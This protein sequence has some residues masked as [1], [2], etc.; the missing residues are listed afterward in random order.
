MIKA[1]TRKKNLD[2]ESYE[3]RSDLCSSNSFDMFAR[4]MNLSIGDQLYKYSSGWGVCLSLLCSVLIGLYV[5]EKLFVQTMLSSNAVS[6]YLDHDQTVTSETGF[7]VAFA[8]TP[9]YS[10]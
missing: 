2:L 6:H 1:K 7:N 5:V 9:S 8:F 3:P 4:P 10:N